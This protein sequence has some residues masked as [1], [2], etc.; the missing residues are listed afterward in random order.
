MNRFEAFC[1][2]TPTGVGYGCFPC[3]H[4]ASVRAYPLLIRGYSPRTPEWEAAAAIEVEAPG[5]RFRLSILDQDALSL[6]MASANLG[7]I[8]RRSRHGQWRDHLAMGLRYTCE[9]ERSTGRLTRA[10]VPQLDSIFGASVNLF[11]GDVARPSSVDITWPLDWRLDPMDILQLPERRD[12][13][14]AQQNEP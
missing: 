2:M 6:L 14:G 4:E 10:W 3:C 12:R 8:V 1:A 11:A 5:E 9:I 7:R 13:T